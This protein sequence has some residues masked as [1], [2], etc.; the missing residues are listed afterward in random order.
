[1]LSTEPP[2]SNGCGQ[3]CCLQ[4]GPICTMLSTL[5]GA[6][7]T[8][9]PPDTN[10][11]QINCSQW[12]RGQ[13]S[14]L[15]GTHVAGACSRLSQAMDCS[16]TPACVLQNDLWSRT[17]LSFRE[18]HL[19]KFVWPAD[20]APRTEDGRGDE[21]QLHAL[22]LAAADEARPYVSGFKVG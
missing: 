21:R 10:G 11:L 16:L 18:R 15:T 7:C 17:S 1:M 8:L 3:P 12:R 13:W 22:V 6:A 5:L 19:A 4:S 14:P 2:A 9:Q 20:T